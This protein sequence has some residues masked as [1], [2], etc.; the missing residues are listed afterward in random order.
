MST[1]TSRLPQ[2]SI[3]PVAS[4]SC[5]GLVLL[6]SIEYDMHYVWNP[7][8]RDILA[9]P[10]NKPLGAERIEYSSDPLVSYGLGYC[11][12][13]R[14]HKLVRMYRVGPGNVFIFDPSVRTLEMIFS[15]GDAAIGEYHSNDNQLPTV[16]L[17][18]E[19]LAWVGNTS[20]NILFSQ[21]SVQV[22]SEVLSRLPAQ[23]VGSLN[24]VCRGWRAVIKDP[25]FVAAHVHNANQNRSPE[26][27]FFGGKAMRVRACQSASSTH[28]TYLVPPLIYD[29]GLRRVICSKPCHGLNAESF[30]YFDF[31]C[32]PITGY[33][34]ALPLDDRSGDWEG[35]SLYDFLKKVP[36]HADVKFAGRL[37]LGYEQETSRHVLVH[38]ECYEETNLATK[39]VCRMKYVEDIFWVKVKK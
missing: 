30:V 5:M 20:E 6:K 15:P 28:H 1:G 17:F 35:L 33:F 22:W 7:F 4:K 14:R 23:M 25:R 36:L 13:T 21:P 26:L 3:F 27:M 10:D 9:L 19:S 34:K 32:N 16:G 24:Q 29:E 37:G 2:G 38:L 31:V 11:S 12:A 39:L 8:T 18:E